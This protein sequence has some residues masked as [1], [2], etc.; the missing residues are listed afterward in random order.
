MK[1]VTHVPSLPPESV[2]SPPSGDTSSSRQWVLVGVADSSQLGTAERTR[3]LEKLRQK[4]AEHGTTWFIQQIMM[5]VVLGEYWIAG[6]LHS[7]FRCYVLLY[8]VI[9]RS[10]GNWTWSHVTCRSMLVSNLNMAVCSELI[11]TSNHYNWHLPTSSTSF[12]C[13]SVTLPG[14]HPQAPWKNRTYLSNAGCSAIYL[15]LLHVAVSS[16]WLEMLV[17]AIVPCHCSHHSLW[18]LYSSLVCPSLLLL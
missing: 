2:E 5:H 3:E 8:I 1:S 9:Y 11:V 7:Q 4:K 14:S 13:A 6:I 10:S 17:H 18:R 16:D 12:C 15:Q